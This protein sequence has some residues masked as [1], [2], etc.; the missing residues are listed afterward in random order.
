MLVI[1]LSLTLKTEKGYEIKLIQ[2][3]GE[4]LTSKDQY[5]KFARLDDNSFSEEITLP[6][7]KNRIEKHPYIE[8][9]IVQY[10]GN[11]IVKVEINEKNI[12]AIIFNG[13]DQFLITERFEILPVLPFTRQLDFPVISNPSLEGALKIGD[14]YHSNIDIVT[15]FKIIE[16]VKLVN[17]ELYSMLSEIDL[18]LGRDIVLAFSNLSFPVVIGRENEIRKVYYFNTLWSFLK[19]NELNNMMDYVDIRY[20]DHVYLGIGQFADGE[21]QQI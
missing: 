9:V 15:G 19:G 21:E 10:D 18:R 3:E 7:I 13:E 6:L 16:T 14:L 12:E 5:L 4:Q 1:Y 8:S 2:V 11:N 20:A 17:P